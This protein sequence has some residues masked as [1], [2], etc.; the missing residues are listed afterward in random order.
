MTLK[1]I[2]SA[3]LH[4]GSPFKGLSH[5]PQEIYLKIKDST[6]LAFDRLVNVAMREKV[7]FILIAGD[8]FDS[9]NPSVQ[10][11]HRFR[12]GLEKLAAENIRV[13]VVHGNHDPLDGRYQAFNWPLNVHVFSA[14]QVERVSYNKGG[15]L[16]AS[17]YGISYKT[18]RV[19]DNL[20]Q[21][22]ERRAE[23]PFAIGLLHTNCDGRE[24][25][26]PY[27]PCSKQ[28]LLRAGMDYW[29]LGHVHTRQI[30]HEDPYI[31]YPGNLQG[32]HIREQGKKGF[33]VVEVDDNKRV[34]LHFHTASAVRWEE[35]EL[36]LSGAQHLDD[37]VERTAE[38]R[39]HLRHREDV[40]MCM[41]RLIGTG[42][43]P[44]AKELSVAEVR[45]ELLEVWREQELIQEK[46]VWPE[47]F[48]FRGQPSYDRKDWKQSE[49]IY[50]DLLE[51]VDQYVGDEL[52]L[53]AVMEE[54][55][56][57]LFGHHK[58]KKYLD[59]LSREEKKALLS[60]AEQLI[61]AR[62]RGGTAQ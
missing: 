27:A 29:A 45:E 15:Q 26:E 6:Y 7:D 16:V 50:A 34:Q 46:V 53:Q 52:R 38:L 24:E 19:T 5:L 51:I 47:S 60:E 33:Y 58:A 23:E 25:H 11:Q 56:K 49:T 20:A 12:Q 8:I 2:H 21:H 62:G 28:D 14:D 31:V 55:L 32:R 37:V 59:P 41:C 36:D 61:F 3:D 30:I 18:A 42:M 48:Q 17:I 39:D 4:L 10:A 22:F 35:H 9:S 57:D 44:L 43:T 40:D 13:F 54:Q 1:F